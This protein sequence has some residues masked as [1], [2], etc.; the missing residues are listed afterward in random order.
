MVSS[1]HK[2]TVQAHRF[3]KNAIVKLEAAGGSAE[4]ITKKVEKTEES[5]T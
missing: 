1:T 4:V 3:S 2:L 5:A